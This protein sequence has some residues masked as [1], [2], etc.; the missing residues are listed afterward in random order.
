M[1]YWQWGLSVPS[2]MLQAGCVQALVWQ[3]WT[4][5]GDVSNFRFPSVTVN[6]LFSACIMPA[7]QEG[8]TECFLWL[9]TEERN[10]GSLW[11]LRVGALTYFHVGMWI[12]PISTLGI[13]D[14][15]YNSHFPCINTH[16]YTHTHTC[17][18]MHHIPES[19]S[20][21]WL[22]NS[23]RRWDTVQWWR[24]SCKTMWFGFS[25]PQ[26]YSHGQTYSA[27]LSLKGVVNILIC[28]YYD[29]ATL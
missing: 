7:H 4:S 11:S 20:C 24:T 1:C 19:L 21:V 3:D 28:C 15:I 14:N 26:L 9:W 16:R 25:T 8:H 6:S 17:M 18:H 10:A 23:S 2:E 5:W 12:I 29:E 13:Y 27:F 22:I